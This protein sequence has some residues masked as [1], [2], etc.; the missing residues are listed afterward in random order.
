MRLT[1]DE[2][3]EPGAGPTRERAIL[4]IMKGEDPAG[5]GEPEGERRP[6]RQA[7][8]RPASAEERRR[9][10]D[11]VR[12]VRFRS[13]LRGYDRGA[14]DRYVKQVNNL[15][16]ELEI[17]AS[18]EAVIKHALEEVSDETRGILERAHE[19]AEVMTSRSRAA[20]DDRLQQA[21][22]EATEAREAAE[23][24]ARELGETA[25]RKAQEL[26]AAAERE[27]RE[28]RQTAQ[29][30]A[31]ELRTAA[32]REAQQLRAAAQREV[33]EMRGEAERRVQQLD[34]HAEAVWQ[35]RRRLMDDLRTVAQQLLE[36]ADNAAARFP[37]IAEVA[38]RGELAAGREPAEETLTGP[39]LPA[40]PQGAPAKN[41]DHV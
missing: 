24:E 30:E 38:A 39:E 37:P 32:E 22:R 5:P 17:S 15:I 11:S 10:H 9:M 6:T 7:R 4:T 3:V 31:Q 34:R 20:A 35:E 29:R 14:V 13:A 41:P 12:E 33:E 25:E 21:D 18:P 36:T 28:L 23:T 2:R 8:K 27:A 16:A 1:R 19:T 40:P 26:R